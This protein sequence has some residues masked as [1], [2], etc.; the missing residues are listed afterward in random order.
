MG[1]N[2]RRFAWVMRKGLPPRRRAIV[3]GV[4]NGRSNAEIAKTMNI[5]VGTVKTNLK[6]A[7]ETVGARDRAGLVALSLRLGLIRFKDVV[8]PGECPGIETF[9]N[10]CQCDCQGC[11]HH[12]SAHQTKGVV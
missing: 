4:A 6:I 11:L 9:P 8:M 1:R 12:C 3:V 2:E 5:T 10:Y 7:F